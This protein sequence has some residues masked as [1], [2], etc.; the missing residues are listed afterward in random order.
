MVL[1]VF[2]DDDII[3][4]VDPTYI[5]KPLLPALLMRHLAAIL[6]PAD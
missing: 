4:D 5:T 2:E 1:E 6:L 3:S